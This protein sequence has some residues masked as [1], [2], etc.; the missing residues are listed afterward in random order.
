[1]STVLA[2]FQ[3][4]SKFPSIAGGTGTGVKYFPK[5][6][7]FSITSPGT[8]PNANSAVGCLLIPA[9]TQTDGRWL[10]VKVAGTFGSDSGDPSGTVNVQLFGVTSFSN[11]NYVELAQTSAI[12]P[13]YAAAEPWMLDVTLLGDSVS[14]LLTGYYWSSLGGILTNSTPKSIDNIL[15]GLDFVNGNPATLQ[16]GAV[17]GLVVGITF[18]TANLTNTARLTQFTVE[19]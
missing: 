1:M 19:S 2:D 17:F 13:T 18:G 10:H 9:G 4:S 6:L 3:V 16:R 5:G 11:P 7:G 8:T 14:G 12:V 15:T